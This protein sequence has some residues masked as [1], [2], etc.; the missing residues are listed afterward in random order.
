M[1]ETAGLSETLDD[2]DG[3][4][5]YSADK[6]RPLSSQQRQKQKK[7]KVQTASTSIPN[8]SSELR[9]MSGTASA[10]EPSQRKSSTSSLHGAGRG[11]GGSRGTRFWSG[12]TGGA[13]RLPD[14]PALCAVRLGM[15]L[16]LR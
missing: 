13:L 10:G 4:L 9:R 8:S 2:L 7:T 14:P 12:G 5:L 15:R 6:N 11:V 1:L 3:L 16:V